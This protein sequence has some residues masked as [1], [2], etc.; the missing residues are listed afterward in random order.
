MGDDFKTKTSW[1][2]SKENQGPWPS[3][4]MMNMWFVH[5]EMGMM[6]ETL[7]NVRKV[8]TDKDDKVK[9]GL[10]AAKG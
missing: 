4:T 8:L 9:Q 5:T 2:H 10:E 7:R 6:I 3:K 1:D